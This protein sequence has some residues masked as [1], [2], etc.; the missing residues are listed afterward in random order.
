M[1]TD[2]SERVAGSV[3]RDAVGLAGI[4]SAIHLPMLYRSLIEGGVCFALLAPQSESGGSSEYCLPSSTEEVHTMEINGIAH[5][6]LAVSNFEACPPF[7]DARRG[8]FAAFA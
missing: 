8:R 6:M 5:V 4:D 2:D 1:M 7:Q 3:V